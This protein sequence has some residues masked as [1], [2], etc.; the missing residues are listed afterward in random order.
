MNNDAQKNTTLIKFDV[1]SIVKIV[2][3]I[4]GLWAL[5][6]FRDVILI[7]LVAGLLAT[8]INPAVNYFE[9]KKIP[10]WMGAFFVYL[11][12]ILVLIL[13]GLAI[14]P[15]VISQ[16]KI[17]VDQTP[18]LLGSILDKMETGMQSSSQSQFLNIITNWLNK[19]SLN[20]GSFFSVLGNVAGQIIS[21][22]MVMIL[23]FYMSVRKKGLRKFIDSLIPHKYQD[24]LKNFL[25]SAQKEIGGWA[26]GLFIICFFVG[27]LA[28]LGLTI[29]GVKY[30]LTLAVIAG[31]TEIIPYLGPWLGAIPA[32]LIAFTQSP[33]LALFVIILYLIIQQIENNFLSPYIMHRAIGLDPLVILVAL[34]VGGKLAGPIGMILSVPA[35]TIV[36]ILIRYYLKLKPRLKEGKE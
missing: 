23:A 28:Y 6:M 10:R 11:G 5:Y 33:T 15:T 9:K 18:E 22:F 24:F 14:I 4:G 35:A 27:L 34:I 36:A 31:L 3:L 25:E 17:L 19:S 32:V 12:V 26:R 30:S 1:W 13:I 16:S 21:V 2:L 7:I 20:L 29:L 8:I